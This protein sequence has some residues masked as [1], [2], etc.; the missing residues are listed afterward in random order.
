ME[1]KNYLHWL[2]GQGFNA[3]PT[4]IAQGGNL[5]LSI[6]NSSASEDIAILN[7]PNQFQVHEMEIYN[8]LSS[9]WMN[10]KKAISVTEIADYTL[11]K[12]TG[13]K[14]EIQAEILKVIKE[15]AAA[16]VV[17]DCRWERSK[18][19]DFSNGAVGEPLLDCRI[20]LVKLNNGNF[21]TVVCLLSEPALLTYCKAFG[22]RIIS[23]PEE[24]L[25]KVPCNYFFIRNHILK[26][27]KISA[28]QKS[29][30]Q[31][32]IKEKT[33]MELYAAD[34]KDSRAVKSVNSYIAGI[35]DSF[36]KIGVIK[37]WEK[38]KNTR[39]ETVYHF[40]TKAGK[41]VEK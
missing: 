21:S 17:I 2:N 6:T 20:D 24:E 5:Y 40:Y 13:F 11:G 26:T 14:Q 27:I 12:R 36:V 23:F 38:L 15:M 7:H 22:N 3:L 8:F 10:G 37:K 4:S 35:F 28:N 9:C 16:S 32:S 29:K 18:K 39:N 30:I 41:E 34:L 25:I 31:N 33:L 19:A 1:R